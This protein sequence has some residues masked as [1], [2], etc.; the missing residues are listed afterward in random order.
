M[1]R[2]SDGEQTVIYMIALPIPAHDAKPAAAPPVVQ[3][4]AAAPPSRALKILG[5]DDE[6]MVREMISDSLTSA[7]HIV[8]SAVNGA[9]ALAR[10]KP[11]YYDL[12]IT[13]RSMPKLN[14]DKLAAAIKARDAELPVIMLTGFGELMLAAGEKPAAIDQVIGKPIGVKRL[15]EMVAAIAP[16]ARPVPAS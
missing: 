6:P 8:M 7:G 9:D 12:V 5:V 11:G 13:D 1:D 14:G 4:T 3:E 15:R 10:F 16:R 2:E